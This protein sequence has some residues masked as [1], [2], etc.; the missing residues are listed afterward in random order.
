VVHCPWEANAG[1]RI[2]IGLKEK[3]LVF[4]RV[5]GMAHMESSPEFNPQNC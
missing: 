4:E 3:N 1:K 5:R 2:I